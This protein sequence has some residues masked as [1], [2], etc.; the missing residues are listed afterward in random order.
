[1]SN[2]Q[3]KNLSFLFAFLFCVGSVMY[4][5]FGP[6]QL[7]RDIWHGF[8]DFLPSFLHTPMPPSPSLASSSLSHLPHRSL[9]IGIASRYHQHDRRQRIRRTW[10]KLAAN[11]A[12][13]VEVFFFFPERPCELDPYWRVRDSLCVP[14]HVFVPVSV[15]DTAPIRPSRVQPS[16]VRPG[17]PYDGLGFHLKFPIAVQQ[18][19]IAQRA[20]RQWA[21]AFPADP[22]RNLTVELLEPATKDVILSVNFSQSILGKANADDGFFY[23]PLPN[24]D[25]ELFPRHFEGVLRVLQPELTLN[26]SLACNLIWNK[27]FGDDGILH[28]TTLYAHGISI[29]FHPETCPLVT[30]VY[31]IPEL[32][33]LKQVVNSHDTQNKCQDN[34]NKNTLGKIVEEIEDHEDIIFVPELTDTQEN[35]PLAFLHFAKIALERYNFD[36]MLVNPDDSFIAIDRLLP[37]LQNEFSLS[38]RSRFHQGEPVVRYGP[39]FERNY[40]GTHYPL[41]P[42][43][44]GSVLSRDL[45]SY[46]ARNSDL[47]VPFRDLTSSLAVWLA[48][49]SPYIIDDVDFTDDNKTCAKNLVVQ[50]P[51]RD[52]ASMNGAWKAYSQC[53]RLCS[54]S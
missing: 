9:I 16:Q 23:A 18:I 52:K 31:R 15:S 7:A 36:F 51:F 4:Q 37:K 42:A 2:T 28:F 20:L 13:S 24:T 1:M 21:R 53:G 41:M 54:C 22:G 35:V 50:G 32:V 6:A 5:L 8:L 34:K 49:I 47:L 11:F 29:P 10:R 46:L 39:M 33:E 12:G 45:V 25:E 17:R 48:S 19:G 43:D 3:V 38:W 27:M 40:L 26:Q 44:A 14:W 30:M